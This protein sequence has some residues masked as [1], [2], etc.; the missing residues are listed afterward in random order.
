M[1]AYILNSDK[2][3][4]F[5]YAHPPDQVSV[6]EHVA[7][8]VSSPQF[9]LTTDAVNQWRKQA[10]IS[11]ST[12]GSQHYNALQ[13][14]GVSIKGGQLVELARELKRENKYEMGVNRLGLCVITQIGGSLIKHIRIH[15]YFGW[16]K[17]GV[18]VPRQDVMRESAMW[19]SLDMHS[20]EI[21]VDVRGIVRAAGE[22]KEEMSN[23][24]TI[25]RK[26]LD[27]MKKEKESS[28]DDVEAGNKE[29]RRS[30]EEMEME[31]ASCR[32]EVEWNVKNEALWSKILGEKNDQLKVLESQRL[33]AEAALRKALG[34]G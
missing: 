25:C 8:D 24:L 7:C 11:P 20:G 2:D 17:Y 30:L 23:E 32:K 29:L 18:Q 1:T 13:V 33:A 3:F 19:N 10:S 5:A 9:V 16:S 4:V 14:F 31:L 6:W 27:S 21:M 26:E 28:G 22:A 12:A 15:D 34:R